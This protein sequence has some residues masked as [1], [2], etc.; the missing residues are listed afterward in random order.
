MTILTENKI[1]IDR[2]INEVYDFVTNMENF[3][4]W[5]PEVIEIKSQNN[6]EHAVVGKRY[7]ETVKDP[8]QIETINYLTQNVDTPNLRLENSIDLE[9][10]IKLLEILDIDSPVE[11]LY[12]LSSNKLSVFDQT[13]LSETKK[14]KEDYYSSL[15]HTYLFQEYLGVESAGWGVGY[16]KKTIFFE[17]ASNIGYTEISCHEKPIRLMIW[18]APRNWSGKISNEYGTPKVLK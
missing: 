17:G 5:F 18:L 16:D 9:T 13:N 4:K 6:L 1:E 7:I 12:A 3:G 14:S 15:F 11:N 8:K 2:S 10:K